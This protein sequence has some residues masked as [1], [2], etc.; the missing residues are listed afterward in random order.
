MTMTDKPDQDS[1][2]TFKTWG[3]REAIDPVVWQNLYRRRLQ[4]MV[5]DL[6]D[7]LREKPSID[8]VF[9]DPA[10][11]TPERLQ[12]GEL[13]VSIDILDDYSS[14]INSALALLAN[15]AA[16]IHK[17][18][19]T[20]EE[21]HK[22]T[23]DPCL[24]YHARYRHLKSRHVYKILKTAI[25]EATMTPAV[26]YEREDGTVGVWIRPISEFLDGRFEPLEYKRS[27][28]CM[29]SE[30]CICDDPDFK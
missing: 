29:I 16:P 11:N 9:I 8:A 20:F 5:R 24:S 1:K 10:V 28:G 25:I 6:N 13:V 18:E 15:E 12:R 30:V 3:N 23:L 2:D 17:P 26:V 21:A 4:Q 27:C 14:R 19:V 22:A 7:E